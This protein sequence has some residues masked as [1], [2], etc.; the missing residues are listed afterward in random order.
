MLSREDYKNYLG[1][2]RNIEN[3]MLG[4]YGKWADKIEDDS[5]KKV[6][7]RISN[8]EKYHI[9]LIEELANLFNF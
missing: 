8:E 9:R 6:F 7:S 3:R 4:F 2:M 5:I 1:Q